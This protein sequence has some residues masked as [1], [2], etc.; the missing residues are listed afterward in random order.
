MRRRK[1]ALIK[2]NNPHLAGGE[3]LI[4]IYRER[5]GDNYIYKELYIYIHIT[6]VAGIYSVIT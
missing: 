5:E 1:S 2:S 3:I 4:Y 6:I